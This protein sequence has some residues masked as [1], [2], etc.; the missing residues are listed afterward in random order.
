MSLINH[1]D[2]AQS[3]HPEILHVLQSPQRSDSATHVPQP[4]SFSYKQMDH[5]AQRLEFLFP[6]KNC[7][8]SFLLHP[9]LDDDDNL[10][11][12]PHNQYPHQYTFVKVP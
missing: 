7:G 4:Q 10:H 8:Y 1:L 12:Q 11:A 9:L 2:D 6:H 5:Y 3:I